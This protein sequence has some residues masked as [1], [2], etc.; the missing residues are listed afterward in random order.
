MSETCCL[1]GN[2][3]NK[4]PFGLN[5]EHPFCI[6]LKNALRK[7]IITKIEFGCLRFITGCSWGADMIC[8]EIVLALKKEYPDIELI[9]VI[10]YEKQASKWKEA[11]RNRYFNILEQ[12]DRMM[13]ISNKYTPDC[14]YE[15]NRYMVD[16]STHLIAVYNGEDK[17][18]TASAIAYARWRGLHITI[19]NPV[20]ICIAHE[21][22]SL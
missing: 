2:M 20:D 21:E 4:L 19:I 3:P 18:G 15:R 6:S 13:L 16:N 17:G 5:E 14:Y 12:S 11:F 22:G 10:P 7:E 1:A 8:S 9:C